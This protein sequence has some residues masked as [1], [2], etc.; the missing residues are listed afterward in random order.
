MLKK[1]SSFHYNSLRTSQKVGE[2]NSFN[3]QF[4]VGQSKKFA[5]I[6]R[7]GVGGGGATCLPHNE[8]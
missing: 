3:F 2:W 6:K 5:A 4:S 7:K 1:I 8:F